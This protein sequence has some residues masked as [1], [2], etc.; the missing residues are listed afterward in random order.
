MLAEALLSRAIDP[1]GALQADARVEPRAG[2]G[3]APMLAELV[4][5]SVTAPAERALLDSLMRGQRGS[6]PGS[7]IAAAASSL[8]A[9]A[10]AW[11]EPVLAE[12]AVQ[13]PRTQIQI[14][15]LAK[16]KFNLLPSSNSGQCQGQTGA[17][18]AGAARSGWLS[19]RRPGHRRGA[20]QSGVCEAGHRGDEARNRAGFR[21]Y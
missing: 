15:I 6:Q 10:E 13:V 21:R 2:A 1:W 14:R 12:L 16:F 9:D 7:A 19:R 3:Q 18:G 11:G 4:G 20:V 5:V 17:A 8:P